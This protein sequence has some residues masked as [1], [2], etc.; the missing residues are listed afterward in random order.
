[1][2]YPAPRMGML[3]SI[4]LHRM[5]CFPNQMGSQTSNN[6][7]TRRRDKDVTSTP[8]RSLITTEEFRRQLDQPQSK[9]F[10][11]YFEGARCRSQVDHW[12]SLD[13]CRGNF[14]RYVGQ[15]EVTV[16]DMTDLGQET[17][18]DDLSSFRILFKFNKIELFVHLATKREREEHK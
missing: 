2:F 13:I 12:T 5:C 7:P 14:V 9:T 16:E 10:G 11:T 15:V 17:P 18:G 3:V 1:M 8:R 6:T 4:T